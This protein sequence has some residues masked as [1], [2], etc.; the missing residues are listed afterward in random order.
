[1]IVGE[2]PIP[3]HKTSAH[4]HN[5]R[6]FVSLSI[7][8]YVALAMGAVILALGIAVKVQTARLDSVKA[9]YASFVQKTR[10][11]GEEQER[12]TKETIAQQK[13]K[14]DDRIKS[15]ETRLT[16][17]RREFDR[18]RNSPGSSQLPPVPETARSVDDAARDK[19]LLGVLQHAQEQ[20]D[21]LIELQE[22]VRAQADG[23]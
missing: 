17:T 15:L 9:E 6:G 2:H 5:C 16:T 14:S 7:M 8:G 4:I 12:R 23:R 19:Q 22:W 3:P 10:L 18:L 20:T 11:I 21:R 13:R 1:M